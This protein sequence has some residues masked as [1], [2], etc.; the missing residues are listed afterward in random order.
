MVDILNQQLTAA[1][2][3]TKTP[4]QALS[5]AQKDLASKIKL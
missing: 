3:G 1:K 5:D 4:A 2:E